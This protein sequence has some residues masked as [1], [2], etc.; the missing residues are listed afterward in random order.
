MSAAMANYH[1][2]LKLNLRGEGEW[3]A[4]VGV[5][6]GLKKEIN[7]DQPIDKKQDDLD[8]GKERIWKERQAN[9]E[10]FGCSR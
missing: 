5:E 9:D 3:S 8:V 4:K 1:E 10:E 2:R 6:E 7:E